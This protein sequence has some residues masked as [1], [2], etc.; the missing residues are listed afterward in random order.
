M[1]SK[2]AAVQLGMFLSRTRV[3]WGN[4][5]IPGTC[6][7]SGGPGSMR[8]HSHGCSC[9]PLTVSAHT[10]SHDR[11]RSGRCH[12]DREQGGSGAGAGLGSGRWVLSPITDSVTLREGQGAHCVTRS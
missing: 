1:S 4:G 3:N 2:A 10:P 5:S 11:S 9:R 12:A 7:L 6:P 8:P